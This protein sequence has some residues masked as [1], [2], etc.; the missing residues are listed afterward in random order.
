MNPSVRTLVFSPDGSLVTFWARKRGGSGGDDISVWAVPTLGGQPRP[1]LEGAAEYDWSHDASRLAYHTPGSGDPLF[2][3]DGNQRA[4]DRLIF[5]VPNGIHAH[6]R[7]WSPD[8]AFIYFVEGSLPDKM[9][10]WRISPAGGNPERI[11]SHISRVSHPV[12]LDRHTL[13]YLVTG[14]DG[15]GPWLYTIDVDRRVPHRLTSGFER[16]TSLAAS[17]DGRRLV[18]TLTSPQKTLWRLHIPDSGVAA[19]APTRIPVTTSSGFSPRCP[20]SSK[21]SSTRLGPPGPGRH[22]FAESLPEYG[23]FTFRI[24]TPPSTQS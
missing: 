17:A 20:T 15:S 4:K 18:L 2:V 16:Y 23:L 1:Y 11:T 13:M 12:F 5:T 21:I 7:V 8:N 6:F 19:T 24:A 3:T 9:D 14:P 22:H 10:I